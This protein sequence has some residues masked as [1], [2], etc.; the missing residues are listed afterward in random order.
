MKNKIIYLFILIF[1]VSLL[2]SA[3]KINGTCDKVSSCNQ[4]K[5]CETKEAEANEESELS[6]PSLGLFL[7]NI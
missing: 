4:Q 7:I 5:C 3:K 6:F 2:S 1:S